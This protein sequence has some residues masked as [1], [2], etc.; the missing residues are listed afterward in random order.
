M[1]AEADVI[2]MKRQDDYYAHRLR[3]GLRLCQVHRQAIQG[4]N[5]SGVT[6]GLAASLVRGLVLKMEDALRLLDEVY[7]PRCMPP[8]P[9]DQLVHKIEDAEYKSDKPWGYLLRDATDAQEVHGGEDPKGSPDG[10]VSSLVTAAASKP[11]N[12]ATVE[13]IGVYGLQ[14]KTIRKDVDGLQLRVVDGPHAG[15]ERRL[16]L[17][18]PR[19]SRSVQRW[20]HLALATGLDEI[21]DPKRE[22][23]RRRIGV[24][25]HPDPKY[26]FRIG[27]F[28][29]PP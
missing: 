15:R 10:A 6:M 20:H 23:L 24:E 13:I 8:W 25:L 21:R 14:T 7:S 19:T 11:A 4:Q 26:G 22:L 3:R 9:Y 27:N 17:D 2:R 12:V 29:T 16:Q 18:W 5:G 28:Y 1:H